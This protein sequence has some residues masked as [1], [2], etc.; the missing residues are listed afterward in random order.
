MTTTAINPLA[1]QQIPVVDLMCDPRASQAANYFSDGF[2]P[3]DAGYALIA[4]ELVKAITSNYPAPQA[5][6]AAMT[7]VP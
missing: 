1:A 2:H 6:C 3:N 4:A 7:A 5:S